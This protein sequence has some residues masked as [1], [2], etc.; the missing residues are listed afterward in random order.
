MQKTPF[1]K[2]KKN[3]SESM[4]EDL[5]SYLPKKWEKIGDVLIIKI[6]KCLENYE[7]IIAKNY[8][9]VLNC[10]SVFKETGGISGTHRKPV[11]KWLY[12]SKDAVTI[13]RENKIRYKIDASQLMF[14]SGN[15]DER[16]RM[17]NISNEN[18]VVVDLFAGIGYF[19]I[20]MAVYSNPKRIYSCEINPLAYKFLCENIV[21]NDVT[22][23]VKPIFGDNL[24]VSPENVADRIIMGYL[25]DTNLFLKTALRCLKNGTGIIHY[26]SKCPDDLIPSKPFKDVENKIKQFKKKAVLI[27][28]INVKSYAPGI[29]HV[30]LD[31]KIEDI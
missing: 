26:H 1:N 2:I 7:T 30:V 19:S 5:I 8:A 10:K 11:L 31:I 15:M 20:P 6:E 22:H 18:E 17:A 27:N 13:H 29:S 3:L 12:G 4:P 9:I 21:L 23:I 24:D 14:S 28:V 16:I 25:N